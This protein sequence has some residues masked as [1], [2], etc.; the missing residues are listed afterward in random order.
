[1][2]LRDRLDAHEDAE[3]REVGG[4]LHGHRHHP[5]RARPRVR[6]PADQQRARDQERDGLPAVQQDH[7]ALRQDGE[8]APGSAGRGDQ[9]DHAVCGGPEAQGEAGQVLRAHRLEDGRSSGLSLRAAGRAIHVCAH[10]RVES[11][12]LGKFATIAYNNLCLQKV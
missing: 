10:F 6:G 4:A 9:R 2:R 12:K 1:M 3:R 11:R 7:R 5:G 8:R